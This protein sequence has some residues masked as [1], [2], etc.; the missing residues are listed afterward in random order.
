MFEYVFTMA[1]ISAY[2]GWLYVCYSV[3]NKTR[4]ECVTS[5]AVYLTSLNIVYSKIFQALSSGINFLS[6]E[7]MNYLSQYNDNVPYSQNEVYNIYNTIDNLNSKSSHKDVLLLKSGT[8]VN[9]GIIS[10]VY[11]GRLGEKDVIIKVKRL[12]VKEKLEDGIKLAEFIAYI[13]SYIPYINKL[14]LK[15]V[16]Q[17]N[18]D[19]LLKQTDFT[20][21][22]ANMIEIKH[23]FRNVDYVTI[24]EPYECFTKINN[25][26]IVMEQIKGYRRNDVEF[27]SNCELKKKFAILIAKFI[28]KSMFLDKTFHSDLHI[29]NV[30]FDNSCEDN[31]KLGIID[32]GLVNKI[33]KHMQTIFFNLFKHIVVNKDFASASR[34]VLDV[35]SPIYHTNKQLTSTEMQ[36]I[37]DKIEPHVK[38]VFELCDNGCSSITSINN[39]LLKYNRRLTSEFYNLYVSLVMSAGLC[40]GLCEKDSKFLHIVKDVIADMFASVE[41]TGL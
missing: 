28:V 11:H 16:V 41:I 33:T 35:I 18:K 39:I 17:E 2:M 20:I 27:D 1:K 6:I 8:C 38:V 3:G 29:G 34:L 21:E 30:F 37:V 25:D 40:N 31:P 32:F 4:L 26:I 15:T 5:T 24:P 22:I 23:K 36:D 12:G 9:S 19:V 10:V 13:C 7:E 14:N